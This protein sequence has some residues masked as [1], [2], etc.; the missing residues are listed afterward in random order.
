MGSKGSKSWIFEKFSKF[1]FRGAL[2]KSQKVGFSRRSPSLTFEAL[3][4]RTKKLDFCGDLQ[5]GLPRRSPKGPKSW[6]FAEI[7]K[8]VVNWTFEVLSKSDFR[9]VCHRSITK[10]VGKTCWIFEALSKVDFRGALQKGQK[11]GFSRRS[12]NWTSETLSK[13][14]KKLDFRGTLQVGLPRRSPKG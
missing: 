1:D 7:S 10:F 2:Q 12:P 8:K 9:D 6:I 13:R 3:F 14:V 4:K 5:V 11:A